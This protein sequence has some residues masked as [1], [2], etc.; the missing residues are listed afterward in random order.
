[1]M[2][3]PSQ[4]GMRMI[5]F[6]IL[7]TPVSIRAFFFKSISFIYGCNTG[8]GEMST[9]S[10]TEDEFKKILKRLF[11][12]KKQKGELKE[13]FHAKVEQLQSLALEEEVAQV[14]TALVESEQKRELLQSQVEHSTAI[15]QELQTKVTFLQEDNREKERVIQESRE[16]HNKQNERWGQEQVLLEKRYEKTHKALA[17]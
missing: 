15:L 17:E 1:M 9:Q 12:E 5:M 3:S 6:A 7:F 11:S 16:L 10:Q 13:K 2:Q 8:R 4:L 14:K